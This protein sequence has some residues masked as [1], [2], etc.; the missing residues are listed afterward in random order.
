MGDIILIYD[1]LSNSVIVNEDGMCM[2]FDNLATAK[3]F[4]EQDEGRY[5]ILVPYEGE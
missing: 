1:T 4:C 5:I 3:V 2:T